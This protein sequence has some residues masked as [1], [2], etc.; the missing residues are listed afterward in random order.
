MYK[1]T[2][3]LEQGCETPFRCLH[4][5][6]FHSGVPRV[7]NP[8]DFSVKLEPRTARKPTWQT[9]WGR[10]L[11]PLL[12]S[13]P[14]VS[15]K[16]LLF[17]SL[18]PWSLHGWLCSLSHVSHQ[19]DSLTW[20]SV[21][22]VL[23]LGSFLEFSAITERITCCCAV[24]SSGCLINAYLMDGCHHLSPNNNVDSNSN[25]HLLKLVCEELS[26]NTYTISD[27]SWYNKGSYIIW[28]SFF[29]FSTVDLQCCVSGCIA[30][31]FSYVFIFSD[32]L[33]F[34]NT[35]MHALTIHPS[36]HPM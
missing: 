2:W 26:L 21:V 25:Y 28:Y 33:I 35:F 12:A 16:S 3:T 1:L 20:V 18:W 8:E 22:C 14:L 5:S 17:L 15:Q 10:M 24:W 27:L 32:G 13:L 9:S 4:A 6:L 34:L 31:W 30:K 29:N 11:D 7:S 23:S 36:Q 19:Q